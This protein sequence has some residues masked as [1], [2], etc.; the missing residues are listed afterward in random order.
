MTSLPWHGEKKIKKKKFG[1]GKELIFGA[2]IPLMCY[3]GSFCFHNFE[4]NKLE[5][6]INSFTRIQRVYDFDKGESVF[7]QVPCGISE[8]DYRKLQEKCLYHNRKAI[9]PFGIFLRD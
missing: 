2:A 9:D 6:I 5:N 4:A 8:R 7:E 3:F 1:F